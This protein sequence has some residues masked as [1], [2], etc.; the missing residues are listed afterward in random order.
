MVVNDDEYI[1]GKLKGVPRFCVGRMYQSGTNNRLNIKSQYVFKFENNY[2]ASI[3]EFYDRFYSGGEQYELVV[4]KYTAME[5]NIV[6]DTSVTDD[7]ERGDEN[8][9]D[10]LLAKIERL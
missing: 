6:Y 5:T 3:V 1:I 4:I 10:E 9:M 8:Y 7:I 2:G